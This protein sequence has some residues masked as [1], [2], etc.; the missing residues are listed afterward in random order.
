MSSRLFQRA[1]IK[2]WRGMVPRFTLMIGN[3]RVQVSGNNLKPAAILTWVN[4]WKAQIIRQVLDVKGGDFIDIGANVGQTLL[5]FYSTGASTRYIGFEPNP[6]SYASLSTLVLENNFKNCVVLPIGLSDSLS[7]LNLYSALG[8]TTDQAAS[9]IPDLRDARGL[10]HS[11]ILCCRFDD[12]G[13]DLGLT[14]IG[15]VKIDVEGAELRVLRGMAG[16]LKELRVPVLCEVLYADKHADMQSYKSNLQ[17]IKRLLDELG[18]SIFRVQKDRHE[19]HFVG[20]MKA[21]AFPVQV[22]TPETKHEC[23]YLLLP[24]EKVLDYQGLMSL[25]TS[26]SQIA[27]NAV[28][29]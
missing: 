22:W 8:A 4:A 7:V 27:D 20:L 24:T 14:S 13:N 5:D 15:L 25:P 11:P 18:Y 23:D 21:S 12:L 16:S 28:S 2:V 9:I 6:I 19:K 10:Q 1:V 26:K 29:G 3:T 17:E